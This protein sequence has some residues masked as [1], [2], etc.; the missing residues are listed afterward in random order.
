MIADLV[1]VLLAAALLALAVRGRAG[2]SWPFTAHL[3]LCLLTNRLITWWPER[4]YTQAFWWA[5]EAAL[6]GLALVVLLGLTRAVLDAFPRA[7]RFTLDAT[8]AILACTAVAA[9][10]ASP[11]D[12]LSLVHGGTVWGFA[13]LLAVTLWFQLPLHPLHRAIMLGFA[14]Y[15]GAYGTVLGL[16]RY[17]E[18]AALPYLA[19]LDAAAYAATLGLWLRAAVRPYAGEPAWPVPQ[20]L[21]RRLA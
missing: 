16:V 17:L 9:A 5:K 19:A 4:F 11:Y 12:A 2:V 18:P 21:A 13:L 15:L 3:G 7:R 20:W 14:L 6:A 1:A 8:A 10:F